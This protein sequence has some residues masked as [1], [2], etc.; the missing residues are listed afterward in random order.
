MKSFQMSK[1]TEQQT[2]LDVCQIIENGNTS[3]RDLQKYLLQIPKR[4]RLQWETCS[5]LISA[6]KRGNKERLQMMIDNLNFDVNSTT[7]DWSDGNWCALAT[8]IHNKKLKLAKY[9]T[10]KPQLNLTLVKNK[11]LKDAMFFGDLD[12]VRFILEQIKADVNSI[13][14][15]EETPEKSFLP[16]HLAICSDYSK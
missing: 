8:A 1:K 5:P 10:T 3:I 13:M 12:S 9:L 2:I 11:I 4:D 7:K 6:V 16:I 14:S 15:Y